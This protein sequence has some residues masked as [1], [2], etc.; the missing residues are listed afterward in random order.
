MGDAA[1]SRR[2]PATVRAAAAIVAVGAAYYFSLGTLADDWRQDTPLA[3]LVLVP[4]LAAA[5]L[6][7]AC[8]RHRHV[9]SFRL[10]RLDLLFAAVFF[11]PALLIVGAGPVLWSKYFWAMRL[12]LLTLPLFAAAAVVLLF[13]SRALIP[14]AFPLAFL[15]LAWPLPY[16]AALEHALNAFTNATAAA[17]AQ[18]T[19]LTNISTPVAGSEEKRYVI[20]H[21][22]SEFVVS[23]ASACS[24]VNS[25]VGFLIVGVAALWLVRGPFLLRIAWLVAGG[26]LC[27]RST[28]FGSSPYSLSPVVSASTLRSSCC[29]RSRGSSPSIS[30]S[31]FCSACCRSSGCVGDHSARTRTRP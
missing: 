20:V 19:T 22:G 25:L 13:G 23:V 17:V 18:V 30:R 21:E 26:A 27:G 2:V 31:S 12:D 6:L 15:L 3:H 5:L 24:G 1:V 8:L 4:P 11:L 9:A 29:I 7:G 16:L 28:S 14:L 10:G